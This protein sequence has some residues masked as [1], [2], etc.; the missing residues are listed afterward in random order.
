MS[1]TTKERPPRGGAFGRGVGRVLSP[2]H[3]PLPVPPSAFR[4]GPLREGAFTS[5]L[6]NRYVAAWLGYA[7]GWSFLVC[8]LT[9][10]YS[11]LVQNPPSWFHNPAHPIWFYRATQGTH[12]ATG[13]ACIPLL[14]AKLWAVYPRLWEWPPV[15]SLAHALERLSLLGLVGGAIFQLVTGLANVYHWYFFAFFFTPTHFFT[16]WVTMGSLAVH[17][18]TK[19]TLARDALRHPERYE[20]PGRGAASVTDDPVAPP[21]LLTSAPGGLS[22][23]GFLGAVAATAG[24]VTFVTVG[25]TVTPL[26]SVD[27][28]GARKPGTGPMHLPVN[29]TAGDAGVTKA[30]A[31]PGY[32]LEVR[33]PQRTVM[34]S[35]ADLAALPQRT[36]RL[37][38]TCVEGWSASGNWT[39]VRISDLLDL[40]GA[41]HHADV[42]VESFQQHSLYRS[43]VL[44]PSHARDPLTL[45]ATRLN[46]ATLAADHGYPARLIAPNRPGVLQTKWVTQLVVLSGNPAHS[47]IALG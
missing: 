15:R 27:L 9:G 40:V 3:R 47:L 18:G 21:G 5:P 2:L 11:H 41:P 14:L 44:E 16:A 38:I 20:L 17:V 46:G 13:I 22:R 6:H 36:V 4:Q 42:R 1:V 35:L 19:I 34:L 31:V 43:S 24:A 37:P 23:R 33:G 8:F 7:L 28:L 30:I 12:V 39:G 25:E 29:V 32:H 26:G 45:L 10:L